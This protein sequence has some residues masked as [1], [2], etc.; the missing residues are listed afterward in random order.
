MIVDSRSMTILLAVYLLLLQNAGSASDHGNR[1]NKHFN[2]FADLLVRHYDGIV[3]HADIPI[4]SGKIELEKVN[5]K[6]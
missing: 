1:L 5:I 3:A 4:S 2:W 6:M